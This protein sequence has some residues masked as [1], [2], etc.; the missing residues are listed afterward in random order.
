MRNS[1]NR[2]VEHAEAMVDLER[3][4]AVAGIRRGLT[5]PGSANCCDCGED[6]SPER[7]AAMPSARRCAN[8]QQR[9]DRVAK[10][11]W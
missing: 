11:G 4:T 5:A 1:G 3:D 2:A 9:R 8:C 6:I 10:R 7:R